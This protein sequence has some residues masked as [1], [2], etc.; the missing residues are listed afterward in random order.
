MKNSSR[1]VGKENAMKFS[2]YEEEDMETF[3]EGEY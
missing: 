3:F 1:F 2:L